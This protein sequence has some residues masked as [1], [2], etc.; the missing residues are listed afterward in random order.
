MPG[1][2]EFRS[3]LFFRKQRWVSG[4]N[5][6]FQKQRWG[7]GHDFFSQK[8]SHLLSL[9]RDSRPDSLA[10]ETGF[11]G[12]HVNATI[13]AL[14]QGLPRQWRRAEPGKGV[15]WQETST[16][17]LLVRW[18]G[19]GIYGRGWY[20]GLWV[21][22]V[23]QGARAGASRNSPGRGATEGVSGAGRPFLVGFEKV[24]CYDRFVGLS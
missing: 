1:T 20:A 3:E 24:A 2:K 11:P 8:Q 13:S 23:C 6:F 18:H 12:P 21:G 22:Y 5:S 16:A 19:P 10:S 17:C 4:R 9:W 7:S 14:S 15:S